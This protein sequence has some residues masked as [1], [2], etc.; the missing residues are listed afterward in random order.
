MLNFFY[1]LEAGGNGFL[2]FK[3]IVLSMLQLKFTSALHK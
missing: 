2:P 1:Q 3:K